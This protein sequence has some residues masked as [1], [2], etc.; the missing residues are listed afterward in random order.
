M[1]SCP[2]SCFFFPPVVASAGGVTFQIRP[3][4]EYN[5]EA[6]KARL[7]TIAGAHLKGA[8]GEQTERD[9]LLHTLSLV[10]LDQ[11][12]LSTSCAAALLYNLSRITSVAEPETDACGELGERSLQGIKLTSLETLHLKECMTLTTE[13]REALAIM[14]EESQKGWG[15][16]RQD[17]TVTLYAM[18]DTLRTPSEC[19]DLGWRTA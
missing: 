5:F 9:R 2:Y 1:T 14:T 16:A 12:P 17:S 15:R 7:S 6:G 4:R 8:P 13:S 10:D 11:A 18:L 19:K 3:A